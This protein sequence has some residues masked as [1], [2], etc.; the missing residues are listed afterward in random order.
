[1]LIF[2]QT[3]FYGSEYQGEKRIQ[4]KF[5][6]ITFVECAFM[7]TS[8]TQKSIAYLPFVDVD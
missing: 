1:M 5:L 7:S 4:K 3:Y 6:Q 8:A 2:I